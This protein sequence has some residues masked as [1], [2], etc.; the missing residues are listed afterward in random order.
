[1]AQNF[2]VGVYARAELNTMGFLAAFGPGLFPRKN[3]ED[4]EELKRYKD[5]PLPRK[6]TDKWR[7]ILEQINGNIVNYPCNFPIKE[8]KPSM[9]D[10]GH[11][12]VNR[13]PQQPVTLFS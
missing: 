2:I 13:L 7:E 3:V 5:I 8:P 10:Y 4:F 9:L 1:L 12:Y 6:N 11:M